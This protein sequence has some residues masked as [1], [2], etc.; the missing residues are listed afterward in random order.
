MSDEAELEHFRASVNCAAVLETMG[1]GWKLDARESTR[2]ALKYRRGEG[3]IL[4]I[5]H[6]GRGWWDPLSCAKG[7]VFDLVQHLDPRLNFGHVRQVLRRLVGVVPGYPVALR[8][9]KARGVARPIPERWS[10][11]PRL[12][13]GSAA[14]RY[15]ADTRALTAAVIDTSAAQD[16]VREGAYG[17]AWFAHR[18]DGEVTH[19]EVRGPD[20]KGSLTGGRKT[21]FRFATGAAP[22]RRLVVAEAPIDALSLAVLEDRRPDT[23]YVATGGGMGPGTIA[24]LQA[25]LGELAA[26]A[27]AL[28]VSA[29][30][31]NAAGDRYAQ[32]H[33]ELAAAAD[34]RFER[35]RPSDGLDW[36]DML[37][38]EKG[39]A[40]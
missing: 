11:R 5:N 39:R 33:A 32:R 29:A 21:L 31:A 13:G 22:V 17:S 37:V 40:A 19:V 38:R 25:L 12:R 24:A 10:R 36:N 4:I 14:W 1:V 26:I 18:Q 3:E 28:M 7:D 15:L 20:Y 35:L 6:D 34:V 30:D 23:L 27:D 9:E 16:A 8:P 2:R